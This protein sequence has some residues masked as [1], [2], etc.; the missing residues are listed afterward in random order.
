MIFFLEDAVTKYHQQ[1]GHFPSTLQDLVTKR[2]I[3]EIPVSPLGAGFTVNQQ[4]G[5]VSEA[6]K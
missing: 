1:F 4:T 3:T 2:I 5:T 6:K